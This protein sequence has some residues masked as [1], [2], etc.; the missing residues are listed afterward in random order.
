MKE[1]KKENNKDMGLLWFI[2]AYVVCFIAF[3]GLYIERV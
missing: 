1:K 2:V 3:I